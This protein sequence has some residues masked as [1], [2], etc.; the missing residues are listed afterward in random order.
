[1]IKILTFAK[2]ELRILRIVEFTNF[3]LR[4]FYPKIRKFVNSSNS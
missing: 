1:M 3:G 4:I 2:T